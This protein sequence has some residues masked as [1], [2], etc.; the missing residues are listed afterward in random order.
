MQSVPVFGN[1]VLVLHSW[2]AWDWAAC[3]ADRMTSLMTTGAHIACTQ[4]TMQPILSWFASYRQIGSCIIPCTHLCLKGDLSGPFGIPPLPYVPILQLK[5]F[6]WL[7]IKADSVQP[8]PCCSG[9][10]Q[11]RVVCKWR[12]MS[13]T[14]KIWLFSVLSVSSPFIYLWRLLCAAVVGKRL[15]RIYV[16]TAK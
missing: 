8:F 1:D 10:K 5:T 2:M 16:H 6:T 9:A 3:R 13:Q 12:E 4:G 15:D 7:C 11:A 14:E